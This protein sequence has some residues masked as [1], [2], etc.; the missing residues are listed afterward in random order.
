MSTCAFAF[1]IIVSILNSLTASSVG[2]GQSSTP[3]F[4]TGILE[5][6]GVVVEGAEPPQPPS[7]SIT[8]MTPPSQFKPHDNKYHQLSTI[9]YIVPVVKNS[10]R[11]KGA[12]RFSG[13]YEVQRGLTLTLGGAKGHSE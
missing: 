11:V 8:F 9:L 2:E 10:S 1:P 12:W 4:F 6:V 7:I 3:R 5:E 13:R